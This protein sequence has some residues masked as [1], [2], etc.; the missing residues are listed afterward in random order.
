MNKVTYNH[1]RWAVDSLGGSTYL[2][3]WAPQGGVQLDRQQSP[4]LSHQQITYFEASVECLLFVNGRYSLAI[5]GRAD[6]LAEALLEHGRPE[7]EYQYECQVADVPRV[8]VAPLLDLV[9][10]YFLDRRFAESQMLVVGV[11][12]RV[13]ERWERD[14]ETCRY[15]PVFARCTAA[16]DDDLLDWSQKLYGA[17]R[18]AGACSGGLA[19]LREALADA[20]LEGPLPGSLLE[21]VDWARAN[22]AREFI[23]PVWA[24]EI[25]GGESQ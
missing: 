2:E 22:M 15:R 3:I 17:A 14:E 10:E 9:Q 7:D 1:I 20:D 21:Y 16:S 11:L 6:G 4:Y 25:F 5:S 8:L 19:T 13:V 24:D 18:Q 12:Q 23:P